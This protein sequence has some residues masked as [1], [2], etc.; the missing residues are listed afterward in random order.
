MRL[1]IDFF[2]LVHRLVISCNLIVSY[3]LQ[4]TSLEVNPLFLMISASIA[5]SFAFMLPVATP[6]N[7]IAFAYGHVTVLDM[8]RVK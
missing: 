1:S 5:C 3:L 4:G 2:T 6:P 7:A 8:V